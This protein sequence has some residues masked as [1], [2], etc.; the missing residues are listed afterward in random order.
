MKKLNLTKTNKNHTSHF[1]PHT[2]KGITLIALVITIIV[3]LILAAVSITMA[4]NGGL[5]GYAQNASAETEDAKVQEQKLASGIVGGQ[6]IEDL[7]TGG[8]SL[9]PGEVIPT[10]GVYFRTSTGTVY[11]SQITNTEK[12]IVNGVL[13]SN[14]YAGVTIDDLTYGGEISPSS[15]ETMDTYLYGDYIYAYNYPIN[16]S[17]ILAGWTADLWDPTRSQTSYGELLNSIN[18]EELTHLYATF[19]SCTSLIT[20]PRIP[21]SVTDMTTAFYEC[22]S[23]TTVSNL[24]NNLRN[25]DYA[26]VRCTSLLTVP[27]IPDNTLSMEYTFDGCISLTKAPSISNSV[28]NMMGTFARC[29][30]I[31]TAQTIPSSVTNIDSTFYGC[32]SLKGTITINANPDI[33]ADCFSGTSQQIYITG[34]SDLL[35]ELAG[36]SNQ[37]NVH[38]I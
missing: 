21:D 26:F 31:T 5:F 18:G 33:Y 12:T 2:S 11:Y 23:L 6:R 32:T 17:D 7:V 8:T 3:M 16:S 29:T 10:G 35:D 19:H 36:T 4:V 1:P 15:I 38:V 14:G 27:K 24:P 28:I 34:S 25:M 22:T 20:A 9:L 37:G 30:G 13:N